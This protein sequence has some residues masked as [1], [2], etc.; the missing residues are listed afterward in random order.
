MRTERLIIKKIELSDADSMFNIWSN[1]EVT[2]FMN[3]DSM[4]T[5]SQAEEMI[6][7]FQKADEEKQANR[8]AIY[9]REDGN[10][11]IGSCGFNYFNCEN[12]RAEIGYE[13]DDKYWRNGY[14][15]EALSALINYGFEEYKLNRIEAKVEINNLPSQNLLERLGFIKEGTLREYEKSNDI[16]QDIVMY[17]MLKYD[18]H[19]LP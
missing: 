7:F 17:S 15:L 4:K 1:D 8:M 3:I 2:K 14:M 13:L 19:L 12:A 6:K 5:K 16:Y 10:K 9:L 18:E 11:A